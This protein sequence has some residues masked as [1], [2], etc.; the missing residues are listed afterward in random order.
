[1][2]PSEFQIKNPPHYLEPRAMHYSIHFKFVN[3]GDFFRRPLYFTSS[4][5]TFIHKRHESPY[6]ISL[7][8]T[9][10]LYKAYS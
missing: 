3:G 9:E 1:M 7:H 6:V 8:K 2:P 10:E 5:W 4:A